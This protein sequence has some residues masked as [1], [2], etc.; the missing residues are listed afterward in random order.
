M[1]QAAN[2]MDQGAWAD[3]MVRR[4][5]ESYYGFRACGWCHD[6]A[7]RRVLDSSC[8]GAIAVARFDAAVVER[9]ERE[10]RF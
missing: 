2:R 10:A 1:E 3:L 4:L 8:A 7:R 5:L 9:S 6:D